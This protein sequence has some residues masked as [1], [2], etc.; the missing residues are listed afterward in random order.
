MIFSSQRRFVLL[1]LL[2]VALILV[3]VGVAGFFYARE[4]LLQQWRDIARLELEETAHVITMRLDE[5]LEL[6]N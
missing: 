4:Y 3:L 5:K 1:L 6:I 2:P